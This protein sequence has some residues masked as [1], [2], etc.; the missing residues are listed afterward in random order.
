LAS[1][2]PFGD[3][4]AVSAALIVTLSSRQKAPFLP[5]EIDVEFG[6]VFIKTALDQIFRTCSTAIARGVQRRLVDKYV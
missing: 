5:D 4:H 6:K 2:L 3:H 1:K